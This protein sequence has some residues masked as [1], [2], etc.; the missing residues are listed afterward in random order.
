MCAPADSLREASWNDS[1]KRKFCGGGSRT[2]IGKK[3]EG[4]A[5]APKCPGCQRTKVGFEF[6]PIHRERDGH[7]LIVYCG[8][9]GV[10]TN[11]EAQEDLTTK[12]LERIKAKNKVEYPK[13]TTLIIQC[14]L[15]ILFLEDEWEYAIQMVKNSGV[16]HRFYEIFVF[17]SNHHY[18]STLYGKHEVKTQ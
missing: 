7:L 4:M 6:A 17:D 10:Y 15:D 8:Q 3:E 13:P 16:V 14:F 11:Y 5:T 2:R 1:N 18:S 12:I 9:C